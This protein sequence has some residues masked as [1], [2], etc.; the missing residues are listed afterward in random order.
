[1]PNGP[2][3]FS[4]HGRKGVTAHHKDVCWP[5]R[6]RRTPGSLAQFVLLL[7]RAGIKWVRGWGL[8]FVELLLFVF[9]AMVVGT[10]TFLPL[11]VR[12]IVLA[13]FHVVSTQ[14]M[15]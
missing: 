9:A 4:Y 2:C 1:M 15:N 3:P 12:L 7:K 6:Y 10:P 5:D 11:L 13:Y 14:T 8:K